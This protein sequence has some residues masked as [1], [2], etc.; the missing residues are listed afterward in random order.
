MLPTDAVQSSL[1]LRAD[2]RGALI[3]DGKARPVVQEA[4]D[5]QPLLLAKTQ[6][7]VPCHQHQWLYESAEA[8]TTDWQLLS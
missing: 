2:G 8:E 1:H 6:L 7:L 3:Q 5:R 4:G